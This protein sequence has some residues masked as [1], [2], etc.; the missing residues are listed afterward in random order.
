MARLG[1]TVFDGGSVRGA[2]AVG[3]RDYEEVWIVAADIQGPGLN[4]R[5]EIGLWATS[6]MTPV[7]AGVIFAVNGIAM[8]FS[9][10]D[11]DIYG[12]VVSP[13]DKGVA[14]VRACVKAALK[15]T[16]SPTR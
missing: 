9:E 13:I 12:E 7:G 5:G 4:G 10:W 11:D 2:Q 14:E 3:S 6:D 15:R 16:P 8:G 1:L